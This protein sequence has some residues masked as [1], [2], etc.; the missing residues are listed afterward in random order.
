M[1]GERVFSRHLWSRSDLCWEITSDI[2]WTPPCTRH[3]A[4]CLPSWAHLY[5]TMNDHDPHAA[6]R[7]RVSSDSSSQKVSLGNTRDSNST[8]LAMEPVEVAVN[9][10]APWKTVAGA[11]SP[12]EIISSTGASSL[13]CVRWFPAS[14]PGLWCT[15]SRLT[16]SQHC[17][18]WRGAHSL[19]TV[20]LPKGSSSPRPLG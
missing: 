5:Q 7:V 15:G 3:A 18:G 2:Y 8:L 14:T 9:H 10:L 4:G 1:S 17:A 16:H 19:Q 11:P 6:W 12:P 20:G 13:E